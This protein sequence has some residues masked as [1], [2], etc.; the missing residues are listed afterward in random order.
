MSNRFPLTLNTGSSTIEELPA[1]DNLDLSGSNISNVGNISGGNTVTA[2]Y[3]V[4]NLYG[5]ANI[6]TTAGTV[7]TAAQPNITSLGTLT[8][9]TSGGTVNLINSSNVSLGPVGNVKVTGGSANQVI[10]TDG[11]GN[12]SFISVSSD[13]YTLKPCR[14]ATTANITLSGAQTIDGVSCTT[15]DRVLVLYQSDNTQNGVYVVA[16]GSWTRATDFTTGANTLTTGTLVP[17]GG[18]GVVNGSVTF[19]C[20]STNA[21]ITIGTT[22]I[23]FE[24]ADNT[25]FLSIW[26][27]SGLYLTK[28]SASGNS[29]AM[30]FGVGSRATVDS[31]AM[32]Y[33]ANASGSQS[34]ALG[35][36][37]STSSLAADSVVA[38]VNGTSTG[39]K[40][41]AV[42]S[43]VS[44]SGANTVSV[45]YSTSAAANSVSIGSYAGS[46]GN[47]HTV[48]V[49][50]FAGDTG[51]AAN[52][53][54]IGP[55]AGRT[56]QAT[57]SI[58]LNATGANLDMTTANTFTVKPVRAVTDVTGFKQLYYNPTTGE[59][60]YYNV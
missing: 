34:I 7:T 25:G 60:V 9:L 52:T 39:P 42:G 36:G 35:Y 4:G 43:G 47:A 37:A 20:V 18:G 17:V 23:N 56:N 33:S 14:A 1:G 19:I 28:A 10:A 12:L 44:V 30:A 3:F 27:A 11:S 29:G 46:G 55:Y 51:Q 48:S 26:N 45:G 6:A 50:F 13:S 21:G 32:G 2:N 58:I 49:G 24:R 22:P 40:T 8:G 15:G 31:S 16:S 57:N 38:G 53:I 54:A 41:V 5:T 59:I